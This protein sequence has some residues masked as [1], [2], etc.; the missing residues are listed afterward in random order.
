MGLLCLLA[1]CG[2]DSGSSGTS[3]TVARGRSLSLQLQLSSPPSAPAASAARQGRLVGVQGRQVQPGA[4]GFIERLEIRLQAQGSD[5]V[6]PQVFTLAPTEQETVTRE[7]TVPDTAPAT[8]QVLVSSFNSQG[9]E[10]FR[11]DTTVAL[12]QTSAVVALVRTA[13]VPVPATPANLQQMTFI[14]ADGTIF[15]LA[16]VPVTLATGTFVGN[17]GDFAL[18][19]NGSVAS[20]NVVIGS[21]TFVAVTSTFPAGQGLHVGDRLV[22]DPCQIDAIDGR[23]IA[24]NAVVSST[25]TISNPPVVIPSDTTLNLPIPPALIIDENT[26]GALQIAASVSGTRPGTIT[27]GLTIPPAHGTATLTNTGVVTYQPVAN[28]NGS[29][30]LVVTVVVLFTDNNFPALLLGTVLIPITV[31]PVIA[32]SVPLQTVSIVSPL[33]PLSSGTIF[34]VTVHVNTGATNVLSYLLALTFDPTVVVVT[35]ITQG[36][37]LFEVPITNPAAFTTGMVKFAANN[38]T[39]APA[40]GVLTLATITFQVIGSP[41]TTSP[42]KLQFPPLSNGGAGVLVDGKFQA[43]GGITF[44]NGVVT[45]N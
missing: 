36:S 17:V 7:V 38:P 30:R 18:T 27:L 45:V 8:F 23:L 12:G 25:P 14:F 41:G 19:G 43:I 24:T 40:N 15:G 35:N 13:L 20:G 6:L 39:F 9:L 29:D 4:P 42:L 31:R 10:V 34:P 22:L 5:L 32:P 44:V 2:G 28:F 21:C 11:G 3:G 16:N 37:A 33:G 26:S 1:G